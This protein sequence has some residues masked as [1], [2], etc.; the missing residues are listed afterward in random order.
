MAGSTYNCVSREG[1]SGEAT[2]AELGTAK[3]LALVLVTD[4]LLPL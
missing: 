3:V 1:C 4:V 2:L